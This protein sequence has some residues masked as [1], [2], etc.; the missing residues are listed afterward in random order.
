MKLMQ[1]PVDSERPFRMPR[2]YGFRNPGNAITWTPAV[3]IFE[4]EHAIAIKVELPEVNKEDIGID[5][6]ED[7]LVITGER[8][9]EREEKLE[10]YTRIERNYG[11][12]C[13]SF[14]LPDYVDKKRISAECENGVLRLTLPK[15]KQMK[16]VP[17]QARVA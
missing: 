7:L 4:D 17:A 11:S 15:N 12:F 5:V 1:A 8:K 3:D 9:L 2:L 16:A 10:D 13:R 14:S 6:Q